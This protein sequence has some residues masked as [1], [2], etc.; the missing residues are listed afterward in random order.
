M[1]PLYRE[2]A[3]TIDAWKRCA[4]NLN[5]SEWEQKHFATIERLQSLLPSGAGIDNGSML[6]LDLSHSD[7]LV[8]KTSFHHMNEV[9]YYDGWTDHVITVTPSFSGINLRISGR[10]RNNIKENLHEEFEY[11]LTRDV[12]YELFVE[13]LPQY[14][15]FSRWE[16]EDGSPSECYQAW[17]CSGKRFWNNLEQAKQYAADL[18]DAGPR[19]H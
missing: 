1:R 14:R 19:K 7:R 10:N 9:G 6:D 4:G 16:N 3:K 5:R 15:L 13:Y 11:A 18:M 17:Y 2:L 12:T 8:I